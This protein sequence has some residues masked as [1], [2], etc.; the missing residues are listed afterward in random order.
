MTKIAVVNYGL[1]N[2]RS[3]R[4]G[5]EE[6][7]AQ[8]IVT[9]EKRG[10]LDADAL[11]LPGVGAFESAITNL[12]GISN[13]L[14][15]QVTAD[16]PLLGICLGLQL[17]F[18]TSTEGGHHNG[19]NVLKG[20]VIKLPPTVKIPHIGWNTLNI[21]KPDHPLLQNVPEGAYVYF[22][23]SYYAAVDNSE[24]VVSHTRYGLTFPSTVVHGAVCATQFHPEKSGKTGLQ[25]LKNFVEFVHS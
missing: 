17:L 3:V 24:S 15:D 18:T 22:V 7:G 6:A 11:V 19:L 8:V 23:H 14:L 12:K 2:I 1:G 5:L 21:V 9:C 16:K 13:V 10:M 20:S 4:R 25:I